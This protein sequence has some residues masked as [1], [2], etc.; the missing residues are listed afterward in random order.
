[1][2]SKVQSVLFKVDKFSLNEAVNFLARHNYKFTKV[3]K[4][5][6]FYRFRQIEPATLR[7]QGYNKYINKEISDGI[8]FVLAYKG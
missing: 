8:T 2:S 3:D 7:R 5:K 1:M 4:T 6:N